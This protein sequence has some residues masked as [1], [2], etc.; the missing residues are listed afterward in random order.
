MATKQDWVV[1]ANDLINARYDWTVLQQRMVLLMIAELNSEAEDFGWQTIHVGDLIDRGQVSGH[2]Y[3]ERVTEAAQVLLDQKIYVKQT[4]GRWRG[5][6][7]LS[8]VEPDTGCIKARFNPDMRPFLLQLKRR[9]TK[10]MLENVMRFQSP[11]STRIY[12]L[13]MQYLDIGHRTIP[14]DALREMLVVEE[15]YPRFYDLRRRVLDQAA[16]E[17]NKL[18][19]LA[20][21]YDVIREGRA[22]VAVRLHMRR[23]AGSA[24]SAP[25]KSGQRA[26]ELE[27]EMDPDRE[28]FEAWWGGQSAEA[29][30]E[31]KERA[32]GRFDPFILQLYLDRPEGIAAQAS[33]REKL[34]EIYL[35]ET[36]VEEDRGR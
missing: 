8:F 10:Y 32:V 7:L 35:D 19:D 22:P 29:Q 14:L 12:E 9:F 26:L 36:V 18:T 15:K 16:K 2:A 30:E 13:A 1:K 21:R 17:I 27:E 20:F 4:S 23:K 31:L 28:A 5:Y 6:N 24:Q 33:L 25:A 34:R 11:Y 3:Y